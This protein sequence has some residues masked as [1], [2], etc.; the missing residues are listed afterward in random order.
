MWR[1]PVHLRTLVLRSLTA[2]DTQ[3]VRPSILRPFTSSADDS[4][5][6]AHSLSAEL[7]KNADVDSVS[8]QQRLQLS[9]SHVK[10]SHTLIHQVLD[11]SSEAGRSV[12]GFQNWVHSHPAFTAS[13]ET[14]ACFINYFGRRKD[15]K[16]VH[17]VLL[18]AKGIAADKTFV[19]VVDRFV[20]AGRPSQLVSFFEK[21]EVD[22]GLV[23]SR[24]SLTVVVEKLCEHGYASYAEKMVKSLAN[25]FFP[26]EKICDLLI[27]GWCND[28]KLDE[29]KRLAGE[30]DRGGFEIGA[31]AYN[32]ILDCVCKLCR[33]KDPFSLQSE[34][35]KIL[36][37]MDVAGVPRDVETFNVLID[38]LCKIRRTEDALNLFHRMGEW[39]CHPN[40]NTFLTLTKSLYQAARIGEGDEMIDRMKSAGYEDQLDKKAY[41]EFL[42]VLCG[43]ERIDHAMS[44][45]TKMKEDGCKPGVKTYDLLMGKLVAHGRVDK[46]NSLF[47]EASK[48]G[49]PVEPKAYK[50]DPRFASKKPVAVKKVKRETLPE[51][52]ARKKRTLQKIRLSFVKKPRKDAYDPLDPKGNITIKWDVVDWTPDGYVAAVK[53]RNFQLYRHI[54]PP[55]WT[56]GWTWAKK[57]I[58]WSMVG[59]QTTEQ[60]DCSNYKGNVPHCCNKNPTVVDLLPEAPYNQQIA[61]CCKGGVISSMVPDPDNTV[62]SFQ[63]TVGAANTTNTTVRLPKNFTLHAPGPGYTCGPVKIV[64]PTRFQTADK[65]GLTRALMTWNI[66]C[67]Y[68]QFL[69]QRNPICCVSKWGPKIPINLSFNVQGTCV[70]QRFTGMLNRTIKSTGKVEIT[71]TNLNYRTNYT[72]MESH[73]AA[74]FWGVKFYNDRLLQAGSVG[75]IQSELLL[76]KDPS[77]TYE[78]GWAFPRRIY[79]NGDNCVMPSSDAYQVMT[80]ADAY[81]MAARCE[82]RTCDLIAPCYLDF[83]GIFGVLVGLCVMAMAMH[84]AFY[85]RHRSKL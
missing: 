71:I 64:K 3:F 11:L 51:K 70:Q 19:A 23:R 5:Q 24:D 75:N 14:Y 15:F 17:D 13:D 59:S 48:N 8:I 18:Q 68:S 7:L 73:E 35:E 63:V 85:E 32:S 61:N 25:E 44:V 21:M 38:N 31:M 74:M 57:E 33:A 58:I 1:S 84:R 50:K 67:T 46:A 79:F 12:L 76:G 28:G 62:S 83:C 47:N 9:F 30:M 22:Y 66:V 78:N 36:I 43:I 56:L 42:K 6:L 49:V 27:K 37:E 80:P 45:F 52:T 26:N 41:Y 34:A 60:G 53:V 55:G 29:A 10:P 4:S 69:A 54:Q 40:A 20:R 65:S 39:G 81:K 2:S 77:F 72:Q 16:A 82:F